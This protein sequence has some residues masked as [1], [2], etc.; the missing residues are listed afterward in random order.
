MAEFVRPL[1]V[2]VVDDEKVIAD[3]IVKILRLHDYDA[4][5]AYSGEDALDQCRDRS[6]F[7]V[8]IDAIMGPISG[9]QLAIHFAKKFPKC[10]VLMI[11]GHAQF[12]TRLPDSKAFSDHFTIFAKPVDPQKIL[13]FLAVP[14]DTSAIRDPR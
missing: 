4:Q 1:R 3:T 10:K 8:I 13:D 11:S 5:A 7:A 9:V 14:V 2:L 12:C 6:P